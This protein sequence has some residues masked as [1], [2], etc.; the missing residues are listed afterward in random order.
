[1]IVA[2]FM[3]EAGPIDMRTTEVTASAVTCGTM[4]MEASLKLQDHDVG[5]S[6]ARVH[7]WIRKARNDAMW[8]TL[9]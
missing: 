7:G 2:L 6:I 9:T 5:Q 1:M 3:H 8:A 4:D